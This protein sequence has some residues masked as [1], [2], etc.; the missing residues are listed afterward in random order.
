MNI[1]S[2]RVSSG[3]VARASTKTQVRSV[4]W[5]NPDS[6]SIGARVVRALVKS[7]IERNSDFYLS[8]VNSVLN[9]R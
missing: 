8:K 7:L 4:R 1:A 6:V 9:S 3:L 5:S 2:E